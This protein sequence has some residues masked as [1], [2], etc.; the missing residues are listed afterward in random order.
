LVYP[1]LRFDLLVVIIPA[2]APDRHTC[3]ALFLRPDRERP[4]I[5][6]FSQSVV[7]IPSELCRPLSRP[8]SLCDI[9]IFEEIGR[10][11]RAVRLL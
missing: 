11:R 9:L 10:G 4:I 7:R 8:L 1:S 2:F 5:F 6:Y 3:T